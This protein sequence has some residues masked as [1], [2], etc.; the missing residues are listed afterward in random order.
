MS[1]INKVM[2]LGDYGTK[3]TDDERANRLLD[4]T[5]KTESGCMEYTGCVQKNGYARATVNRVTDYAH[6]HIYRMLIGELPKGLDVCHKC[7]NRKCI[8]PEHLFLGTRAENMAD[9]KRNGRTAKGF[10]LPHTKI[11]D[12]IRKYIVAMAKD[13]V[14]YKHIA[15]EVG[16]C[17]QRVGQVAIKE[18][19]RRNGIR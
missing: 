16:I 13:G 18:G 19:I 1:S 6:R 2:C 5:V 14:K 9:A 15:S 8:N 4:R 7:D 12:D 10:D 11:S 3:R 17:R